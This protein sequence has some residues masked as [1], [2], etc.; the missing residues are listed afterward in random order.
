M[1]ELLKACVE[2]VQ[3]YNAGK[4]TVDSHATDFIARKRIEDEHDQ[5]FLQQAHPRAPQRAGA[6]A[7]SSAACARLSPQCAARVRRSST[8]AH[9]TRSS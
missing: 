8:G 5:R 6:C 7:R 9:G 1:A 4:C 3:S 2:L